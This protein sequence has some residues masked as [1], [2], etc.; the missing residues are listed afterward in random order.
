MYKF[1]LQDC[2]RK[3]CYQAMQINA[4]IGCCSGMV[5][6]TWLDEYQDERILNDIQIHNVNQIYLD[7]VIMYMAK[8][9]LQM[10]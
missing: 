10:L 2:D 3:A 4:F 7:F 5:V 9:Q 6:K 1:I 8:L